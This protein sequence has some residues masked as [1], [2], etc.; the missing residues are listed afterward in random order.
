[1]RYLA[2]LVLLLSCACAHAASVRWPA[3]LD[4]SVER[5]KY[6]MHLKVV[7][8][9]KSDNVAEK[10]EDGSV[11]YADDWAVC[12][13]NKLLLGMV[14]TD[15][16]GRVRITSASEKSTVKWSGAVRYK[17][18]DEITLIADRCELDQKVG[19]ILPGNHPRL[20]GAPTNQLLTLLD[21]RVQ[22]A[23][24]LRDALARLAPGA[25]AEVEKA[26]A[27]FDAG[28]IEDFTKL[29]PEADLLFDFCAVAQYTPDLCDLPR[30]QHDDKTNKRLTLL[31]LR[32]ICGLSQGGAET[33]L[34]L[35]AAKGNGPLRLLYPAELDDKTALAALRSLSASNQLEALLGWLLRHDVPGPDM[36]RAARWAAA[37]AAGGD[38]TSE[39]CEWALIE[40]GEEGFLDHGLL[41]SLFTPKGQESGLSYAFERKAR[42]LAAWM[43]LCSPV[44]GNGGKDV[45]A[46]PLPEAVRK[47]VTELYGGIEMLQVYAYTLALRGA[48]DERV[49]AVRGQIDG[50]YVG[51]GKLDLADFADVQREL[52]FKDKLTPAIRRAAGRVAPERR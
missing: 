38:A 13:V 18:G 42:R 49:K 30:P 19:M 52:R 23:L 50:R 47:Q 20:Q 3:A 36:P 26:L 12:E 43:L 21:N 10:F 40:A 16:D 22:R 48:E 11:L 32:G 24:E 29:S 15:G 45:Q 17:V 8:L 1:M 7:G 25:Q 31:A 33:A 27:A 14:A 6:I 41:I 35:V 9:E 51:N 44:D 4:A 46:S 5:A 28:E 39:K 2:L 37:L 34:P